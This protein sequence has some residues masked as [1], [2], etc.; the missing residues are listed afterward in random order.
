M[1]DEATDEVDW[2]DREQRAFDAFDPVPHI[3]VYWCEQTVRN[4]LCRVRYIR[5][6]RHE[7]DADYDECLDNFDGLLELLFDDYPCARETV[8][9]L[10]RF[11]KKDEEEAEEEPDDLIAQLQRVARAQGSAGVRRFLRANVIDRMRQARFADDV[12]RTVD[13]FRS[14]SGFCPSAACAWVSAAAEQKTSDRP[15]THPIVV[16]G[17]DLV[18]GDAVRNTNT[19]IS[20]SLGPVIWEMIR[21]SLASRPKLDSVELLRRTSVA[22]SNCV[23]GGNARR[24]LLR[25]EKIRERRSENEEGEWVDLD[26]VNNDGRYNVVFTL[27]EKIKFD[28]ISNP[29]VLRNFT[30]N[31]PVAHLRDASAVFKHRHAWSDAAVIHR[32]RL[33]VPT[34]SHAQLA[35]LVRKHVLHDLY[36]KRRSGGRGGVLFRFPINIACREF[37]NNKKAMDALWTSESAKGKEEGGDERDQDQCSLLVVPPSVSADAEDLFFE[38]PVDPDTFDFSL[39]AETCDMMSQRAIDYS[40]S[41]V[42]D[43]IASTV[44]AAGRTAGGEGEKI[45]P[46]SAAPAAEWVTVMLLWWSLMCVRLSAAKARPFAKQITRGIIF[47]PGYT[48]RVPDTEDVAY[49]SHRLTLMS[50]NSHNDLLT[51][52]LNCPSFRQ[53]SATLVA[54]GEYI[55]SDAYRIPTFEQFFVLMRIWLHNAYGL[56]VLTLLEGAWLDRLCP[57]SGEE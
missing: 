34:V 53:S 21:L 46:K 23:C 24:F 55:E 28:P 22:F 18:A 16:F 42:R 50:V 31:A 4:V 5:D 39:S 54:Y 38:T 49:A 48:R 13:A 26:D 7:I 1:G 20:R 10:A 47:G 12:V 29:A 52:M 56:D 40:G 2:N 14:V 43:F 27:H 6:Y 41:A 30:F 44:D 57:S 36:R 35:D 33:L 45:A 8:T 3:V 9:P 51:L 25:Y 15:K 17:D 11:K 37:I 32:M 19:E